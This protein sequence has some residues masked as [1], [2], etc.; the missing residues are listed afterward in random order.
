MLFSLAEEGEVASGKKERLKVKG[1]SMLEAVKLEADFLDNDACRVSSGKV[2]PW[3]TLTLSY[4]VT[5][6]DR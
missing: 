5:E 2:I 1:V 4:L 3:A 6:K